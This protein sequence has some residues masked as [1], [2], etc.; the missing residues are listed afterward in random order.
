MWKRGE[1]RRGAS[2]REEDEEESVRGQTDLRE[3]RNERKG[4]NKNWTG[5]WWEEDG[6]GE[7]RRKGKRSKWE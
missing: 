7:K 3:V 5:R 1:E 2:G 6:A 4:E